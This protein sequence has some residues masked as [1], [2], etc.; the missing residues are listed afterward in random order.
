MV[1][2]R[3]GC[4]MLYEINY[5]VYEDGCPKMG[6]KFTRDEKE[7]DKI[8]KEIEDNGGQTLVSAYEEMKRMYT[9]YEIF[10]DGFRFN[11]FTSDDRF[12][13]EVWMEN[14][15]ECTN[16]LKMGE[17]KLKIEED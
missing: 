6:R 10:P 11:L 3:K 8:C 17:S 13:C 16:A 2:G 14:H 4:R 7:A 12:T 1:T 15:R 9:V 5:L